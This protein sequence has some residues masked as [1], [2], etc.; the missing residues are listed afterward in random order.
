MSNSL[1]QIN[2]GINQPIEFRGLQAQYIGWLGGGLVG[3]LIGFA[4]L[5]ISGV[6]PFICVGVIMIAGWW[7]FARVF[8]MSHRYGEHGMM[9]KLARRKVPKCVK[10]YS[11]AL[12]TQKIS[13]WNNH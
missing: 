11:R 7:L 1:Y 9:K 4:A 10:S 12:F 8:R 2:K 3:L 6:N 13:G 5:Y